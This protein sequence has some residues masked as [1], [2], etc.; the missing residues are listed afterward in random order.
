[1]AKQKKDTIAEKLGISSE[2]VDQ[3]ARM[4]KTPADLTGP[5]GLM[6]QLL[7]AIMARTTSVEQVSSWVMPTINR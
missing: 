4:V 1:M 2:T 6:P 7:K 5:Q 3:L